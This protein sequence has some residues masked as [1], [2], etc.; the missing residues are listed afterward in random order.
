MA[1]KKRPARGRAAR[2][3]RYNEDE[4]RLIAEARFMPASERVKPIP[5]ETREKHLVALVAGLE[6]LRTGRTTEQHA[7]SLQAQLNET[8]VVFEMGIYEESAEHLAVCQRTRSALYSV[9]H[10]SL[11][12][13]CMQATEA[14]LQTVKEFADLRALLLN[15]PCYTIG[16]S[17]DA[18]VKVLKAWKSGQ[19]ITNIHTCEVTAHA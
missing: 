18:R 9:F 7:Y 5:Q 19:Y 11:K 4:L 12:S 2:V 1:T 13:G 3:R 14:E 15:D 6:D 17:M 16:V 10:R 8:L